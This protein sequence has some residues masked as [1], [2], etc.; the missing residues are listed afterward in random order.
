[1]FVACASSNNKTSINQVETQENKEV[2]DLQKQADELAAAI[3]KDNG[4]VK[5]CCK[6]D[7]SY[8]CEMPNAGQMNTSCFCRAGDIALGYGKYCK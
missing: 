4:S 3:E 5:H 8:I 1:M 7:G 6:L 2:R